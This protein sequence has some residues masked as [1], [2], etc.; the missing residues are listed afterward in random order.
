AVP[1]GKAAGSKVIALVNPPPLLA[2]AIASRNRQVLALPAAQFATFAAPSPMLFTTAPAVVF[3]RVNA[4]EG[5]PAVPAVTVHPPAPPVA[6][7]VTLAA[8]P[9]IVAGL[10]VSVA[11][12]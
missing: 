2:A 9:A 7:A 12:W 6:V 10:P 11:D 4:T 1:A 3:V 5:A 8:P